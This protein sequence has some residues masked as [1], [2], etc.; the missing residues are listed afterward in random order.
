MN[1]LSLTPECGPPDELKSVLGKTFGVADAYLFV[2]Q[3]WTNFVG[4]DLKQWPNI[5]AYMDRVAARPAVQTA[6]KKEGLLAA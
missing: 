3:N 1:P 2:L 4:I 6:M 5:T